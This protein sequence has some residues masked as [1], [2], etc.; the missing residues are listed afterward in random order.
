MTSGE[1]RGHDRERQQHSEPHGEECQLA[2]LDATDARRRR[3]PPL[4]DPRR[5]RLGG[6]DS[7]AA[8]RARCRRRGHSVAALPARMRGRRWRALRGHR[9]RTGSHRGGGGSEGSVIDAGPLRLAAGCHRDRTGRPP[10]TTPPTRLPTCRDPGLAL[11][12]AQGDGHGV[13]RLVSPLGFEPRTKGLKVPCSTAELRA[14]WSRRGFVLGLSEQLNPR[15][16]LV[17]CTP[18]AER[19]IRAGATACLAG[20]RGATSSRT[21]GSYPAA[22]RR[23]RLARP[24]ADGRRT[25]PMRSLIAGC[26]PDQ[27][28]DTGSV[29]CALLPAA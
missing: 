5:R 26:C 22:P 21:A 23:P 16:R 12:A 3:R 27:L 4:A 6:R 13:T 11:G 19:A 9:S 14:H 15:P 2:S 1:H 10:R 17:L 28:Q 25:S 20:A 29:G 18:L 7:G 8:R 24:R